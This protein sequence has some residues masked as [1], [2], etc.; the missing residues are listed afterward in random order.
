MRE[1]IWVETGTR[2]GWTCSVC[3]WVF[4]P[5]GPPLGK[6]IEEMKRNYESQ[7]QKE[8]AAHVCAQHPKAKGP[9]DK[10]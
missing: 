9:G 7:G 10:S 8:F 2:R 3:A 4:K 5:S 6:T 1:M